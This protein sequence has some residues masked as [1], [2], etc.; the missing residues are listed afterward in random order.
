MNKIYLFFYTK[1]IDFL[2]IHKI[3]GFYTLGE[4]KELK[5]GEWKS[6]HVNIKGKCPYCNKFIEA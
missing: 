3:F 2:C 6:K 5:K 4:L 1:I